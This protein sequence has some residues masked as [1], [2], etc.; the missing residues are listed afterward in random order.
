MMASQSMTIFAAAALTAHCECT[1][2]S[3][4]ILSSYTRGKEEA[5]NVVWR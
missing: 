2:Y 1:E 4:Y 5:I 3:V